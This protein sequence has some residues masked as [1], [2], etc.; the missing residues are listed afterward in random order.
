MFSKCL[1]RHDVVRVFVSSLVLVFVRAILSWY[2]LT[3]HIY[4]VYNILWTSLQFI[5]QL[6]CV[7]F[8][9]GRIPFVYNNVKYV[10]VFTSVSPPNQHSWLHQHGPL[11]PVNHCLHPVR[12]Q[13]WWT[14]D[15]VV[16]CSNHNMLNPN[17]RVSSVHLYTERCLTAFLKHLK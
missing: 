11:Y 14:T 13:P 10:L 17:T 4:I 6:L 16:S 8:G 3:W 12:S 7:L 2:P 15:Q 5:L 1:L 9:C